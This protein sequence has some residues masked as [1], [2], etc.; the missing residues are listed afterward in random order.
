MVLFAAIVA[1]SVGGLV[2]LPLAGLLT[3]GKAHALADRR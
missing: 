1:L 3:E 2:L